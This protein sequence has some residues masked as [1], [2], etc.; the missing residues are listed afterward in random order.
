MWHHSLCCSGHAIVRRLQAIAATLTMIGS[1]TDVRPQCH[2]RGS[3]MA[4]IESVLAASECCCASQHP[5]VAHV[6]HMQV[7]SVLLLPWLLH[8]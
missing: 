8:M 1:T 2:T 5:H 7:V 4:V 3:P 6:M